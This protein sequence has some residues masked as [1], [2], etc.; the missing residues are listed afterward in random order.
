MTVSRPSPAGGDDDD[1]VVI[2]LRRSD[3]LHRK[4]HNL[5]DTLED[6]PEAPQEGDLGILETDLR[7]EIEDDDTYPPPVEGDPFEQEDTEEYYPMDDD[8]LRIEVDE[9]D[10]LRGEAE[11][12]VRRPP[13]VS[14]TESEAQDVDYEPVDFTDPQVNL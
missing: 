9:L 1:D 12:P 14:S 4:K 5:K 13:S 8:D 10:A 6:P 7:F 3:R 2:I 11:E